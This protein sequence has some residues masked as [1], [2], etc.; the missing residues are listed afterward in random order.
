MTARQLA[1]RVLH[2]VAYAPPDGLPVRHWRL[3]WL[4]IPARLLIALPVSLVLWPTFLLAT[5]IVWIC[6][7]TGGLFSRL[8]VTLYNR[9]LRR[10]GWTRRGARVVA[11]ELS[12]KWQPGGSRPDFPQYPGDPGDEPGA[13]PWMP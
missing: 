12:D 3:I 9:D 2:T 7:W 13:C 1:S 10:S 6:D 5:G 11:P 4:S 8:Y